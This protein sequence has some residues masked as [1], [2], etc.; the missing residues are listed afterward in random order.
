[1]EERIELSRDA[2]ADLASQAA[3]EVSGVVE[4]LQSPVEAL[5]SRIKREFIRH[6]VKVEEEGGGYRFAVHVSVR[7]GES[8]PRIADEIRRRVKEYM[9][10][11]AG[12]RV[13]GVDVVV[14]GVD[15][16]EKAGGGGGSAA[17]S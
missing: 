12:V 4:C 11:T 6:G 17:S 16:P 10:A 3:L 2:L 14:E 13:T 8:I 7:F 15:F 5:A 1:M 9:E